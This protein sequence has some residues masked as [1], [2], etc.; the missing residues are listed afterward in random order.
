MFLNQLLDEIS[1]IEDL[2]FIEGENV[3]VYKNNA[4]VCKL[5]NLDSHL[6]FSTFDGRTKTTEYDTPQSM[7]YWLLSNKES[8]YGFHIAELKKKEKE[9]N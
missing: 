4:L 3:I 1:K 6:V 7:H 8:A 2:S 9:N 5:S